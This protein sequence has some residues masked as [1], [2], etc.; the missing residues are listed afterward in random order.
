MIWQM[1]TFVIVAAPPNGQ[2]R[3]SLLLYPIPVTVITYEN[4]RFWHSVSATGREHS[5]SSFTTELIRV[6]TG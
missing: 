3:L 4:K 6:L 2:S 5:A 1:R